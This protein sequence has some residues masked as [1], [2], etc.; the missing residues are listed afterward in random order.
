MKINRLTFLILLTL[1]LFSCKKDE[2]GFTKVKEIESL[3][4]QTIKIYREDNGLTGPFVHQFVMVKEAQIYSY[5][6]ANDAEAMGTQGLE[7][8]W[9]TIHEKIGGYNDQ[10]LVLSS[11]SDDEDVIFSQMLQQPDAES[12]LLED[13]TQ[14]GVGVESDTAGTN[15]ITILLMK[16]DS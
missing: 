8:H 14:C 12:I 6:M 13:L 7:E 2:G 15:Y 9:N 1:L 3:I 10:A 4:Y 16:V 11:G 5:K